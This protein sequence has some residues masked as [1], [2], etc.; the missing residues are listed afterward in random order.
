MFCWV[1]YEYFAEI[2]YGIFYEVFYRVFYG[3]FYGEKLH[4][5]FLTLI[6]FSTMEVVSKPLMGFV[7]PF[8]LTFYRFLMGTFIMFFFV[9]FRGRLKE[10]KNI[11]SLDFAK[12]VLMGFLNIFFSMSMLQLAIEAGNA[13]TAAVIFCSNP[14]FVLLILVFLG[15][16][17]GSFKNFA[18]IIIGIIGT[19]FIMKDK[20]VGFNYGSIYA[21]L[22]AVSFAVYSVVAKSS[23]KNISPTLANLVSFM[24]GIIFL[25]IY[26]LFIGTGFGK[27]FG[28]SDLFSNESTLYYNIFAFIY[29]GVALSGF[30]YILFFKTLKRFSAVAS[31][32]IFLLKPLIATVLSILLLSEPVGIN[33]WTGLLFIVLGISIIL[34]PKKQKL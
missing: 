2:F 22:S 27:G 17:R 18:P 4:Y 13:G 34:L 21:I 10:L 6:L 32:Y 7:D 12:L 33:F 24:A 19:F 23:L 30:G 11:K 15:K 9:L 26:I 25:S 1:F 14:L 28:L 8:V 29:I 5:F 20:T 3:V 31:S 16:E